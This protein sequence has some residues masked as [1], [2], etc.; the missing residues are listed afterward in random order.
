[1]S[2]NE[3]AEGL[4]AETKPSKPEMEKADK[5]VFDFLN[6]LGPGESA[7]GK[8][9]QREAAK[10]EKK[11]DW[12]VMFNIN[13]SPSNKPFNDLF[14]APAP[15]EP[16]KPSPKLTGPPSRAGTT[17]APETNFGGI[18]WLDTG[19]ASTLNFANPSPAPWGNSA[20][21]SNPPAAGAAKGNIGLFDDPFAELE[22]RNKQNEPVVQS[23]V[24]AQAK[25]VKKELSPSVI[26][27]VDDFF[28]DY[29]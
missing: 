12:D 19:A 13:A 21:F 8:F 23:S 29:V 6:Q 17:K 9:A 16:S 15:H 28:K 2:S 18:N 7:E 10:E 3:A 4:S 1:M 11:D 24:V 22:K 14:Q 5:D 27:A 26:S 25:E 20:G